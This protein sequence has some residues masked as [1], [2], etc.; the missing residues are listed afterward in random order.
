M[1]IQF[2]GKTSGAASAGDHSQAT[3]GVLDTSGADFLIGFFSQYA[4]VG[5]SG[6]LSD[7]KGNSWTPLTRRTDNGNFSLA[8]YWCVPPS[9]KVGS[10]HQATANGDSIGF[11]SV[12]MMAFSGLA[13]SPFQLEDGN[14]GTPS[15]A[16]QAA[17]LSNNMTDDGLVIAALMIAST[18]NGSAP[19]V[20]SSFNTSNQVWEDYIG[21]ASVALSMAYRIVP[22]QNISQQWTWSATE[23]SYACELASFSAAIVTPD[24]QASLIEPMILSARF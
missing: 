21:G 20:G 11:F 5:N 7:T 18:L 3:T 23:Q 9:N 19:T 16:T 1:A 4:G 8:G 17:S 22:K 6:V 2:I 10:G 12:G 14:Q 13:A 15:P 24:L